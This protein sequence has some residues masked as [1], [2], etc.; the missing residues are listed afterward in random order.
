MKAFLCTNGT[1]TRCDAPKVTGTLIELAAQFGF[2][3]VDSG[4]DQSAERG[5]IVCRPTNQQEVFLTIHGSERSIYGLAIWVHGDGGT[6]IFASTPF[7]LV[8]AA[9]HVARYER[10]MHEASHYARK[11]S[12]EPVP[13]R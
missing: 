2:E 7:D 13:L 6:F 12:E 8:L 4:T 1:L 5:C 10:A 11:R 3:P 9:E